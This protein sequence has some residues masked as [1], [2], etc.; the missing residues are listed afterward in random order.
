[1]LTV[2]NEV[3][4]D[5]T[6]Q[7][8]WAILADFDSYPEWNPLSPRMK[9]KLKAGKTLRGTL[10][11]GPKIKLPFFPKMAVVEPNSTFRWVGGVPGVLIADHSFIIEP[12]PSGRSLFRHREE[13]TGLV[14]SA[15]KG[16]TTRLANQIHWRFNAAIKQRAESGA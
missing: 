12:L 5:A 14:P 10:S 15:S 6:P 4:I 13:F 9:G 1:M 16:L 11:L 7:Q 8:L 3:E 2:S